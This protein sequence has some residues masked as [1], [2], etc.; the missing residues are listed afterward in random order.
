MNSR[1]LK[2]RYFKFFEERGHT[3]IPST[4]LI[5]EESSTLFIS[6]GMQ[7]LIP[8]LLGKDHPKGKR[9]VDVQRCLRTVDIDEVGDNFHHTFFEMLGNWSLGDYWKKES[10]SWS[11]EFLTKNLQLDQK[12]LAVTVF[13]GDDDAPKDEESISVWKS[14]G[15]PDNKITP[16][17]RED[18][19]WGPVSE[20]G[21]CGP[22]SE[23]FYWAG[24]GEPEGN[25]AT[26]SRWVEI[27]NNVFIQYNKTTVGNYEPLLQKSI[28]TGMGVERMVAT[29]QGQSDDYLTELFL[30]LIKKVEQLTQKEYPQNLKLMRRIVDHIRAAVFVIADGVTPSN[31]E[32]GYVL[33]RLIRRSLRYLYQLGSDTKNVLGVA[34]TVID[35]Y[36][37]DYPQLT[38]QSADI[39]EILTEEQQRFLQPINKV[40]QY[41]QDLE[42]AINHGVIKRIGSTPILKSQ[43][44][45]SGEY[46]FENYQS[47]GVPSDLAI[48]TV[49]DLKISFD[50]KGYETAVKKHQERSR[51]ASAGMF[52]AGLKSTGEMETKYHTATHLLQAALR[53]VL[54][55]HVIQRGSNITQE[56]LRFDFSHNAKP[57]T[58]Q[59]KQVEDL[60][61]QKIQEDLT[62]THEEM[63]QEEAEQSGAI[64]AFGEKYGQRVTVYSI[65]D[66]SKEYCGGPHVKNTGV[67]GTFKI[68]KEEST[69]SGIRRI[70]ATLV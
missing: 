61:N 52:K 33:R 35:L 23:I 70:Y 48:E 53:Q 19:W 28:D 29:L 37:T 63:D 47:Y 20:T 27:W 11:W 26:D 18:N 3:V 58:E 41:R 24:D 42:A 67:L 4:S 66:F 69:G 1:I 17:G 22:D 32:R 46:V 45:A 64:H 49:G 6:A 68:Q 9:L 8:Y 43:G 34:K 31:T 55:D 16:L 10:I 44:V 62:L 65:G 14:L 21:P 50:Q 54:G 39:L 38:E 60:V 5:P 13:A 56:R 30:P 51:S 15:I 2:E 59:L 7:P 12:R 36:V 40:E 25:P 57:A